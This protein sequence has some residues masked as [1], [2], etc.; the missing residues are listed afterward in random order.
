MKFGMRPILNNTC[1]S[2]YALEKRKQCTALMN[3]S[4]ADDRSRRRHFFRTEG[5]IA[6]A[7]NEGI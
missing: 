6:A 3:A 1:R 2:F 4:N 7:P 5:D